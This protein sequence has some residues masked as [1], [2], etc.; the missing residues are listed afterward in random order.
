MRFKPN[1]GALYDVRRMPELIVYLDGIATKVA[2]KANGELHPE[3]D[4]YP[5]GTEHFRTGSQ[6]G[7][8]K[9]QGRWRATVV[10]AT[11]YAKRANAKHNILLKALEPE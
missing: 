3:V 9:P 4:G 11:E 8:K 10:T 5:E 2:A 1:R 7:R 6:Q